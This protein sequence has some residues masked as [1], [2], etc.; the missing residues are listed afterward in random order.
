MTNMLYES[1]ENDLEV[2]IPGV[3]SG[4]V[5]ASISA[6]TMNYKGGNVWTAMPPAGTSSVNVTVRANV[7]GGNP[8][9]IDKEFRVRR[10]PAAQAYME[11]R[12]ASGTTQRFDGGGIARR[13]LLDAGGIRAGVDDG[14]L[15]IPYTVTGFQLR[16]FDAMGNV[17]PMISQSGSFTQE[18]LNRIREYPI[19]RSFIITNITALDPGGN[20][21]SLAGAMEVTIR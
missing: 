8:I 12:D 18:Q 10:L 21:R 14:V 13:N 5:T 15:D 6:G 4:S 16:F 9:S 3:P 11:Y 1:I 7:A 19:G 20:Q 17:V 2:A